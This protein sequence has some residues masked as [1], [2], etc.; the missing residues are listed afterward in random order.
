MMTSTTTNYVMDEIRLTSSFNYLLQ[1]LQH[2]TLIETKKVIPNK[3]CFN[4]SQDHWST[5][6]GTKTT[7]VGGRGG[8][9]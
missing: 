2:L 6:Q 7:G 9:Y 1:V 3:L 8:E 5:V 4:D